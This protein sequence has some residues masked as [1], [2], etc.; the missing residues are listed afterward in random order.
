MEGEGSGREDV[1]EVEVE[2]DVVI[3]VGIMEVVEVVEVVMLVGDVVLEDE[4]VVEMGGTLVVL[5]VVMEVDVEDVEV[6]VVVMKVLV[7]VVVAGGGGPS[8]LVPFKD[9]TYALKLY[10]SHLSTIFKPPYPFKTGEPF[11]V[12]IKY[13]F[14]TPIVKLVVTIPAGTSIDTG[15]LSPL[16][17][18]RVAGFVRSVVT[19]ISSASISRPL[20]GPRV[21]FVQVIPLGVGR[22]QY[23]S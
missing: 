4:D 8:L 23:T 7:E 2:E 20:G 12:T 1:E 13:W 6:E 18:T 11:L 19:N 15:V 16:V 17:T 10:F 21:S 22:Y 5:V 14:P 3:V 9:P